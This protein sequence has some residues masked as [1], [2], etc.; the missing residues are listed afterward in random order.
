[1]RRFSK[2]VTLVRGL[3]VGET[4]LER[5]TKT[6]KSRLAT[7]GTVKNGEILLQGEHRDSVKHLLVQFG[8]PEAAIEVQ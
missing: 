5:I 1:M 7:G 6:L 2:P 3:H 4:E 8:F